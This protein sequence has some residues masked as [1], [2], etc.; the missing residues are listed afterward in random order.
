M[1]SVLR[2]NSEVGEIFLSLF[3][4]FISFVYLCGTME[5]K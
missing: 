4:H 3:L 2:D 5:T 1:S